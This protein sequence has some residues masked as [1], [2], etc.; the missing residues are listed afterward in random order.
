M[1]SRTKQQPDVAGNP[2]SKPSDTLEAEVKASGHTFLCLGLSLQGCK[3]Q[4]TKVAACRISSNRILDIC[5]AAYELV[6][7]TALNTIKGAALGGLVG[8]IISFGS[9]AQAGTKHPAWSF[10]GSSK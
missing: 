6:H 4:R 8:F 10:M 1:H 2:S 7:G 9:E 3:E 5:C